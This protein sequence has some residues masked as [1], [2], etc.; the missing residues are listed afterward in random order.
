VVATT[1]VSPKNITIGSKALSG[2]ENT[3]FHS[4]PSL[5]LTLLYPYLKSI[6]INTFFVTI[7]PLCLTHCCSIYYRVK[8]C[9]FYDT[10]IGSTIVISV[11]TSCSRCCFLIFSTYSVMSFTYGCHTLNTL[12]IGI[13]SYRYSPVSL[14]FIN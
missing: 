9:F 7:D 6:F 13:Y 8:G 11:S 3:A 1:F 4:S 10:M 14:Y 5:I 2:I 12:S